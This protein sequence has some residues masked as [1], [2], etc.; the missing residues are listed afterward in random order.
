MVCIALKK[1]CILLEVNVSPNFTINGIKAETQ[2]AGLFC[3]CFD[4]IEKARFRAEHKFKVL[5]LSI[6]E[7][8]LLEINSRGL[9]VVRFITEF[10][11]V[12]NA[13]QPHRSIFHWGSACSKRPLE[14]FLHLAY[15]RWEI[16]LTIWNVLH[17]LLL[18][19]KI[20][21]ICHPSTDNTAGSNAKVPS[22]ILCAGTFAWI[23]YL[24]QRIPFLAPLTESISLWSL[25]ETYPFKYPGIEVTPNEHSSLI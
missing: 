16:E 1:S 18:A 9:Q 10:T 20:S 11:T 13:A 25:A 24:K 4:L 22:R 21:R 12:S 2:P 19:G 8:V 3:C 15:S 7:A 23:H 14:I 5:N 6:T 17:W